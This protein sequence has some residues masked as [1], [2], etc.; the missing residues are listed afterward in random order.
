MD[1][2]FYCEIQGLIA[3]SRLGMTDIDIFTNLYELVKKKTV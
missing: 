3:V 1:S 2:L